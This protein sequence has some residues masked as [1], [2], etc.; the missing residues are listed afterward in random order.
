MLINSIEMSYFFR[1]YKSDKIVFSKDKEKNVTVIKGDNGT[2]KT[3]MLSA[4]SWV[5]YGKVES[6]L[7]IEE[8]MN[9]KR[10]SEM[11]AGETET[12]YVQ[13][14]IDNNN[15][16]YI[17]K[18]SQ[19]FRKV[20]QYKAELYGKPEFFV[21]ELSAPGK[22]INDEDF[23]TRI[24]PED[25]R[26]FFFFDGERIDRLAQIDGKEEI[27]KAILDILGLTTLEKLNKVLADVAKEFNSEAKKNT[28][29]KESQAL[30]DEYDA[31]VSDIENTKKDIELNEK[32]AKKQKEV[33]TKCKAFLA[34]HNAAVVK[35]LS[36]ERDELV[37]RNNDK[38]EE[39]NQL[40][41]DIFKHISKNFK[42]VL[43]S[44]YL[45][46]IDEILEEKREKGE[47]P[48]D[49]KAQFIKD[50]LENKKCI[51]GRELIEGTEWYDNMVNISITAG[52]EELDNAYV[53]MKAFINSDETKSKIADFFGKIYQYKKD[54]SDRESIIEKNNERIKKIKNELSNDYGELIAANENLLEQAENE[55]RQLEIDIEIRKHELE[56]AQSKLKSIEQKKKL[57]QGK[58]DN[59]N[60]FEEAL[61]IATVLKELNAENREFFIKMTREDMNKKLKEVFSVIARKDDREIELTENF[62]LIIQNRVSKKSQILSQGERQITS[63]AFIGALVAYSKEKMES[64]LLTDFSGGD[65]PIVMDSPFGNLDAQ[66]KGHTA[67]NLP[68]LASQMIVIVSEEQWKGTVCDNMYSKVNCLYEMYDGEHTGDDDEYTEIRRVS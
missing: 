36:K 65:F 60:M 7:V 12:S 46:K 63:L 33:I 28:K 49:I 16:K 59:K 62:E 23:F 51:C 3:T 64:K 24:I 48:S 21:A 50:L 68:K 47:L 8:M 66:H 42:Y 27:R 40:K 57:L 4:F 37:D 14:E 45:P 38:I 54:V 44:G 58:A 29:D 13:V 10:L 25:L 6:P 32:E 15:K 18:R 20:E 43:I 30:A 61:G 52:R 1:M 34:E 17:L 35:E 5:F 55:L 41:Q 56:S 39:I 53:L 11:E 22:N 2:G 19:K 9:K 67:Y 31:C 26:G